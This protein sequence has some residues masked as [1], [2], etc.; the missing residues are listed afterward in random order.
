MTGLEHATGDEA[1]DDDDDDELARPPWQRAAIC[2]VSAVILGSS[3]LAH[4]PDVFGGERV[5]PIGEAVLHAAGIEMNWI[6]FAP[7]PPDRSTYLEA[8]ITFSDGSTTTWRPPEQEPLIGTYWQYRWDK[9][10]E[11]LTSTA[12]SWGPEQYAES[13]RRRTERDTGRAVERVELVILRRAID[14]LGG[15]W[16]EEIIATVT[17][18]AEG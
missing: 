16:S 15:A 10:T 18:E 7:N 4:T 8:R 13:V 5:R 2:A 12:S 17:R 6:V 14:P 11:F 1:V 9:T 3:V